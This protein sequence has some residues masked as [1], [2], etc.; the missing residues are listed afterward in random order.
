M[1]NNAFRKSLAIGIIILFLGASVIPS[2]SGSDRNVETNQKDKKI[3]RNVI[4]YGKLGEAP[5]P[6]WKEGQIWWYQINKLNINQEGISLN[7]NPF[8]LKV[9]IKD[10]TTDSCIL[11]LEGDITADISIG[12]GGLSISGSLISTKLDG[13][14]NFDKTDLGL[15]K[16]T[17]LISGT[18]DRG[19]GHLI[20]Y[21]PFELNI[22]F[23]PR[24]NVYNFFDFPITEGEIWT[25]SSEVLDI[26]ITAKY[27]LIG[28]QTIT[29]NDEILIDEHDVRCVGV[30]IVNG[31]ETH[32]V[33]GLSD[34]WYS[35]S[36][37]NIVK[38]VCSLE[39]I[40]IDMDYVRINGID[41]SHHNDVIDW[42]KVYNAGY[43]FAFLKATEDSYLEWPEW[44]PQN[45]QASYGMGM[46]VNPYHFAYPEGITSEEQL[47]DAR[48]EANHFVN[49]AGPYIT[50]GYL[51]PALDVEDIGTPKS[52]P[53]N[54]DWLALSAW[55]HEWINTVESLTGVQPMVYANPN[56]AS[57]LDN[58]LEVYCLW[59]CDID[60][61]P[62]RIGIWEDWVFWQYDWTGSVLG[63]NGDV[64]KDV[65]NGG[66]H[67]LKE[68]IIVGL[69]INK[70]SGGIGIK[71]TIK[72][73]G[74]GDNDYNEIFDGNAADIEWSITFQNGNII[75]PEDG[76]KEGMINEIKAGNE[77]SVSTYVFGFGK[78]D[79]IIEANSR[80]GSDKETVSAFVLGPIVTI[81]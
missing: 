68:F 54:G 51:C 37:E 67:Q 56:Y 15:K 62:P 46:I 2:I 45:I 9:K 53:L 21:V 31:F 65:F 35:S 47:Q 20:R 6:I 22:E 32:H 80:S 39:G 71:A 28:W 44:F 29:H 73:N 19:I 72:N 61:S 76:I 11:T 58:S 69:D 77:A 78:V 81:L 63:I 36:L 52:V 23:E 49:I 57:N 13:E 30:E 48:D 25:V 50:K 55:I 26:S 74:D 10:V 66:M 40:E 17:I 70:I 38:L 4:F 12:I 75:W 79:I 60:Q 16:L 34:Y 33:K 3:S 5:K 24:N 8:Y 64:D 59:I 43:R 7:T 1:K 27:K 14:L 18:L 41:V 42:S